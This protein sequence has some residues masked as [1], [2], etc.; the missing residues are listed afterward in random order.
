MNHTARLNTMD[1]PSGRDCEHGNKRG[2]CEKCD[3]EEEIKELKSHIERC[4][5][6]LRFP[7][8]LRKMWSGGEVQQWIDNQMRSNNG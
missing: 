3:Y 1:Y 2:K 4:R 6:L 5:G 7:V 8:E